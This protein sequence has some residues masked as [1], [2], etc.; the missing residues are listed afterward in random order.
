[1]S[2]AP[3]LWPSTGRDIPVPREPAVA[4]SA[5]H[6]ATR[7]AAAEDNEGGRA[8]A[9]TCPM[10]TG[11]EPPSHHASRPADVCQQTATRRNAPP[12]R[13]RRGHAGPPAQPRRP[14][15]SSGGRRGEQRRTLRIELP[16]ERH[17]ELVLAR[18]RWLHSRDASVTPCCSSL[19]PSF[20]SAAI[21]TSQVLHRPGLSRRVPRLCSSSRHPRL[22]LLRMPPSPNGPPLLESAVL[23]R[24]AAKEIARGHGRPPR[25]ERS[26][27]ARTLEA[28]VSKLVSSPRQP[29]HLDEARAPCFHHQCVGHL[30]TGKQNHNSQICAISPVICTQGS[31]TLDVCGN[32]SVNSS[33]F[34]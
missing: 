15:Y 10:G 26:G 5:W 14:S 33:L 11:A 20:L 31:C 17:G 7:W 19:R 13:E 23:L 16:G 25:R 28:R 27:A 34:S 22:H 29:L 1:L 6:R 21:V 30:D 2:F 4:P 24:A 9:S 3:P 32:A 18:G 8:A 12:P